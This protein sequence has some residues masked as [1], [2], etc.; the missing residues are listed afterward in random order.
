[1]M[2]IKIRNIYRFQVGAP[3]P[4]G[5]EP[6]PEEILTLIRTPESN[7]VALKTGYGKYITCAVDGRLEAMQEAI[8]VRERFEFVFDDVSCNFVL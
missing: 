8:G 5:E 3:H 2:F 6:S 1:M 4:V 7:W